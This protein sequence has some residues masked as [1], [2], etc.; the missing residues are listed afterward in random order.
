MARKFTQS[1]FIKKANEIHNNKY[2]YDKVNYINKRTKVIITCPIHG[3]FE[4]LPSGH[5]NGKY[6]CPL[7]GHMLISTSLKKPTKKF[8]A[9]ANIVHN[10]TY[11]YTLITDELVGTRTKIPIVCPKHG[12]FYQRVDIHLSGCICKKCS[13]ELKSLNTKGIFKSNSG[14]TYS[15]W[16]KAGTLSNNFKAFSM[17]VLE[18]YNDSEKFYKI[19]K[20]FTSITDRY[21]G[22][23]MMPYEWKLYFIAS[24]ESRKIS[25]LEQL[26][27]N[28]LK[29]FKYLPKIEFGGWTE[30][31]SDRALEAINTLIKKEF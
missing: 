30:C 1:E 3:D 29:E 26:F 20:T 21:A 19:G 6:G 13:N 18:C 24:G 5:I 2:N 16:E 8:I 23:S 10:N 15:S 25:K 7:C 27:H 14:W 17:Y 12:I 4:Q 28:C 22:S 9:E 11:D 31:F